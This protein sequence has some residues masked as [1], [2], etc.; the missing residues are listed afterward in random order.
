MVSRLLGLLSHVA[1]EFPAEPYVIKKQK[2]RG[3]AIIALILKITA[4][5]AL[6]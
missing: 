1:R 4:Y 5:P 6:G 2:I 3:L